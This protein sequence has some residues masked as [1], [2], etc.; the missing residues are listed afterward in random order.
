MKPLPS[1][2]YPSQQSKLFM[3]KK[4]RRDN[5]IEAPELTLEF[6]LGTTL[7]K[8]VHVDIEH[9]VA[10]FEWP[11]GTSAADLL[12]NAVGTDT[13]EGFTSTYIQHVAQGLELLHEA[14]IIHQ[15]LAVYVTMGHV[16]SD[17]ELIFKLANFGDASGS[18]PF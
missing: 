4:F 16:S 3:A 14:G 8:K 1:M 11:C 10:V 6:P 15:D 13:L 12:A 5:K 2:E 18:C 7:A 9:K 17:G